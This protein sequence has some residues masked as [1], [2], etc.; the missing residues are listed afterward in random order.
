M[1]IILLQTIDKLGVKDEVKNVSDGYALNYL[2]P[3]KLA[4]PASG[5][6][7]EQLEQKKARA[8]EGL[9]RTRTELNKLKGELAGKIVKIHGKANVQGKLFAQVKAEEIAFKI[10]QEYN[11]SIE[12]DAL[13]ITEPIKKL[14]EYTVNVAIPGGDRFMVQVKVEAA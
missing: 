2:L 10:E 14:G 9:A 12:P 5:E 3:N 1:K 13:E 11:V 8:A 4:L 6:A 7:I